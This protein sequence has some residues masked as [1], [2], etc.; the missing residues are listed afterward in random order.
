MEIPDQ[1]Q[2]LFDDA[3]KIGILHKDQES[4]SGPA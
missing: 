4:F 1:F 2:R 3:T